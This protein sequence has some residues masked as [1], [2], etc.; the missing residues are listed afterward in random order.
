MVELQFNG[1]RTVFPT[2]SAGTTDL[3][4]KKG[5]KPKKQLST[6]V[7]HPMQELTQKKES[8][9]KTAKWLTDLNG[10]CKT[11]KLSEENVG[12]NIWDLG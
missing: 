3:T 2:N 12:E 4:D 5:Q 7:S 9:Q 8:T 11:R 6:Q 1:G 10:E